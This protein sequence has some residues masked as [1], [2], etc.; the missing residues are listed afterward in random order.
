MADKVEQTQDAL[1]QQGTSTQEQPKLTSEETANV[2][3]EK[4]ETKEETKMFPEDEVE[5][6]A[7]Q[8]AQSL[9]DKELKPLYDELNA[10]K[11]RIQEIE[12]ARL[13]AEEDAK[14]VIR[15]KE[16]QA[17][18]EE[19]G[20]PPESIED[21]HKRTRT[22][23]KRESALKEAEAEVRQLAQ[24][25]NES[26]KKATVTDAVLKYAVKKHPELQA[27]ID[28]ILEEIKDARD[29]REVGYILQIREL[30]GGKKSEAKKITHKP[31]SS[32]TSSSSNVKYYTREQVAAICASP[33]RYEKEHEA[34]AEALSQGRIT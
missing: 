1:E 14:Q 26:A 34:I 5:K 19:L 28:S 12:R 9:K 29:D 24:E 32:V 11:K 22:L 4:V 20:V 16:E 3:T 27:E 18:L 15:E 8:K 25:A 30:G 21:F 10:T 13:R 2:S 7:F 17:R 31:D 23:S 6:R 33:E